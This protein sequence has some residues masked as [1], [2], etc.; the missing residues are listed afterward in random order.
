MIDEPE[1][2][3]HPQAIEIIR[4]ALKLLSTEG[5]QVIFSTHSPLM[6]THNDVGN[7][8][9]IRKSAG[10]GTHTRRTLKS[11]IPAIEH[12]APSQIQLMFSLSNSSNILFSEKIFLTEGVTEL[13]VL[14]K[15]FEKLT[16]SS[17]GVHKCCIVKQGGVASTRKSMSVLDVM[18]LPNKAVVDL[19]YIFKYAETDGFIPANDPDIAACR[20]GMQQLAGAQGI[21]LGSDGWPV[22]KN[23]SMSASQAFASLAKDAFIAVNIS[24]LHDKL[25]VHNIWAWKKGAIEEHLGITAKSET[26]WA[27]FCSR[28]EAGTIATVVIDHQ[29]V[30]NCIQWLLN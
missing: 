3:L 12:N 17:L 13:R 9:L 6:I 11:A 7:T 10:L 4:E 26:A 23:S 22:N 5:Y 19:D 20:L 16:G 15:I 27:G 24:N 25:K 21:A 1:L 30:T 28:L 8:V 2:Y 14:P 18:D 29:E